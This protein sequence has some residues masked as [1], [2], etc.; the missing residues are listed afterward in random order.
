[1]V[2]K[3]NYFGMIAEWKSGN[4][5]QLNVP[6]NATLKEFQDIL[7]NNCP[8]LSGI[9]YSIAINNHMA[10]ENVILQ[11]YDDISVFPP[12]AGG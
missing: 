9:S 10:K 1:M 5:E 11:P 4:R 3:V 8:E 7:V 6:E 12:F 2:V